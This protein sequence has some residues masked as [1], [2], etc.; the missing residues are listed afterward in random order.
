MTVYDGAVK[1]VD[2]DGQELQTWRVV[3]YQY[4]LGLTTTTVTARNGLEAA[5]RVRQQEKA[6]S[7]TSAP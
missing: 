5:D 3:V 4:G 2:K 6:V 1:I 7:Q